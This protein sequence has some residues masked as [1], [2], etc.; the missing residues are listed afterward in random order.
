M[1]SISGAPR[2]LVERDS[3]EPTNNAVV[4]FNGSQSR[5]PISGLVQAARLAHG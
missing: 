3:I 1:S 5:C 4:E 2:Q